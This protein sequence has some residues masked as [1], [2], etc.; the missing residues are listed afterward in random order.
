MK[1]LDYCLLCKVTAEFVD[2]C[3]YSNTQICSYVMTTSQGMES[4]P[5]GNENQ[6]LAYFTFCIAGKLHHFNFKRLYGF[7]DC[8]CLCSLLVFGENY[9]LGGI[10]DLGR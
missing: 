1:M 10:V 3:G 2:V 5:Q 4:E 8:V 9:D 6:N 7:E